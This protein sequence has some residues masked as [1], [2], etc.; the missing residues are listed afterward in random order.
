[1][2]NNAER[3]AKNKL[4][5][6]GNVFV[7]NNCG[8]FTVVS[9]RNKRDVL[10]KFTQTGYEVKVELS[11]IKKGTVKDRMF[12]EVMGIGIVGD[13]VT[14]VN[15]KHTKE[16]TLWRGI[17]ERCYNPKKHLKLPTYVGC[18]VSE[19][20]KYFP[21]FEDW[22]NKQISFGLLDNNGKTFHLDKDLLFKGNKIYSEDTCVFVPQEINNLL[23][24]PKLTVN[25]YPVGVHYDKALSKYI[26]QVSLG[27]K[28]KGL[29]SFDTPEEAFKVYKQAKEAYIKEVANK[30]K[31]VLDQRA[32]QALIHYE[33]EI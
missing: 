23:T 12:P 16:Y 33:I 9:Y 15:G 8:E 25:G 1:M 24:K 20:F 26:A 6:E 21:H 18:S 27:A 2:A 14:K 30:W 4:E 3:L 28:M 7:S 17:L 11:Q 10:I 5:Y 32:H 22:C 13:S 19:S 31:S 29:G